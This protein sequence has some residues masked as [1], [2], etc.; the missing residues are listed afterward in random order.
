MKPE[1]QRARLWWRGDIYDGGGGGGEEQGGLVT[2][3]RR[4]AKSLVQRSEVTA[5]G[6]A[7]T[8]RWKHSWGVEN[9]LFMWVEWNQLGFR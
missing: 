7:V 1:G 9:N 8:E 4:A 5:T 3:I 2:L 6:R